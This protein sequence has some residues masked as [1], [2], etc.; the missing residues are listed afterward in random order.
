MNRRKYVLSK[1]IMF[2][3]KEKADKFRDVL[4]KFAVKY[5]LMLDIHTNA[6]M[7]T[8]HDDVI[9]TLTGKQ[10]CLQDNELARKELEVIE[11]TQDTN[12]KE[13]VD[14]VV[15][16]FGLKPRRSRPWFMKLLC[17]ATCCCLFVDGYSRSI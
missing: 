6:E 13:Y 2:D 4:I 14:N 11:L 17:F 8:I 1:T 9:H 7:Y 5:F 3:D 15:K 10:I 16:V 12:Q